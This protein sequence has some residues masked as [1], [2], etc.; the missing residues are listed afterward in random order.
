MRHTTHITSCLTCQGSGRIT[1]KHRA[2]PNW[3]SAGT[4]EIVCQDCSGR[5]FHRDPIGAAVDE[6]LA[7]PYRPG[8]W[9]R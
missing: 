3:I 2:I 6:L 7:A 5:G 9:I 4:Q 1:V 8:S